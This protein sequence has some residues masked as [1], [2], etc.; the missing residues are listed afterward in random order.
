MRGAMTWQSTAREYRELIGDPDWDSRFLRDKGLKPN[1]LDLLGNCEDAA[2]LDAGA[3][4]GWLFES[5]VPAA[6][7]ACDIVAPEKT[8]ESVKFEQQ[9]VEALSYADDTFDVVVASLLLMFCKRLE[10]ACAELYRVTKGEG[11]CLVVA[12]THPYFYRTGEVLENDGFILTKDLSRPFEIPIKIAGKVGPLTYYYRPLPE[13]VNQLVKAGWRIT[14]LRDWFIDI[15][16]YKET[17]G[18]GMKSEIRRSGRIPLY[19]FLKCEK[20]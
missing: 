15:E 18:R 1:I 20:P 12:L 17:M 13:Y 10:T 6:A 8:P 11:G 3:G 16:Q 19:T 14:E 7:Y 9:D 5:I 4:T 2:V